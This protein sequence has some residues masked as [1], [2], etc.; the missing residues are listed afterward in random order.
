MWTKAVYKPL[1][2]EL[3]TEKGAGTE[4]VL[5]SVEKKPSYTWV[6]AQV[7]WERESSNVLIINALSC[8][9]K[10]VVDKLLTFLF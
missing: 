6:Y 5:T 4:G 2:C 10:W 7:L 3:Y 9:E 1:T 8:F